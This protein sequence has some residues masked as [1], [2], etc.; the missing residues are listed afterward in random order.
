MNKRLQQF[1]SAE[2]ITQSQFADSIGVAKASVSHILAGRNKPGFE[3][4]EGIATRYPDLSLD[5]LILGKGKMFK[6]QTQQQLQSPQGVE[7]EEFP[8][9]SLFSSENENLAAGADGPIMAQTPLQDAPE[10]TQ[11]A[12]KATSGNAAHICRIVVFYDDGTYR[13]LQ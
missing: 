6:S 1:L 8:A 13:E 4:I 9:F 7:N 5:W 10:P 12:V 11:G 3:F 2:N